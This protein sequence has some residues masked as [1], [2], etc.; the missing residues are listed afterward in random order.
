MDI[1]GMFNGIIE[2]LAKYALNRAE[3][4]LASSSRLTL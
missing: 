2:E 3:R 1:N 4:M